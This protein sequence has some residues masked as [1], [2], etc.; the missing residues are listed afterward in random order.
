MNTT[1]RRPRALAVV[2]CL[3]G[4]WSPGVPAQEVEP[5][6]VAP[7]ATPR[8]V[9]EIPEV[10]A[11]SQ[12]TQLRL[13]EID[14][15]VASAP[16]GEIVAELDDFAN[17]VAER[18]VTVDETRLDTLPQLGREELEQEWQGYRS[19]LAGWQARLLEISSAFEANRLELDETRD[20]WQRTMVG[21][22]DEEAP[23]VLLGRIR[24]V[25]SSLDSTRDEVSAARDAALTALDT[26]ADIRIEVD[27][28]LE[29]IAASS[30]DI[31]ARMLTRDSPP[32]WSVLAGAPRRD[33]GDEVGV[34]LLRPPA[35]G[36]DELSLDR[37]RRFVEREWAS[38]E[39]ILVLLVALAVVLLVARR[40]LARDQVDEA[41]RPRI[42][43]VVQRPLA[44]AVLT[45]A[46]MAAWLVPGMP[47]IVR[48]VVSLVVLASWLRL[49][50]VAAPGPLRLGFYAIAVVYLADHYGR[51]LIEDQPWSRLY[52]LA[53]S[54]AAAAIGVRALRRDGPLRAMMPVGWG[55]LFRALV[56]VATL[57]LI[58]AA[59]ANIVG[60]VTL[61]QLLTRATVTSAAV[62]AVL[63]LAV[64]VLDAVVLLLM[65]RS[66][67]WLLRAVHDNARKIEG[68]LLGLV[69]LGAMVIWT[70]ATLTQFGVRDRF[71]AWLGDAITREWVVGNA[72]FSLAKV[73]TIVAVFIATLLVSRLIRALLE[74]DVFTRVELPR[75]VPNAVSTLVR[76]AFV[77]LALL[78]APLAAGV[79]FSNLAFIAG[80]L[81]VGIG[82]GLQNIVANFVSGLI[83]AF[84]RPVQVGDT[85]Q[86]AGHLGSVR[87]I[88]VRSSTIR[89]FDGADV[90]VPNSN[91]VSDVVLNWTLSDMRRRMQ[92]D[93]TVAYGADPHRVLELLRQAAAGHED[94]FDD[95]PPLA[96]FRGFTDT[97][98]AFRLLFW[99]P[100]AKALTAPSEVG[101]AIFDALEREGYDMPI[102]RQRVDVQEHRDDERRSES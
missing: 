11:R 73:L 95:P 33:D 85:I 24:E 23:D 72:S 37:L 19:R 41:V 74:H 47:L 15:A 67:P 25:I 100:T 44:G 3:W 50:P 46:L 86:A 1:A 14:E 59:I 20:L 8:P 34:G 83:L 4:L 60:A 57:L 66:T 62:A 12:E 101:L 27:R 94:V 28:V 81:G 5:S 17:R 79:D 93:V 91:M 69:S 40:R 88:G 18:L 2:L 49:I 87:S 38:L 56:P 68:W 10:T 35:P 22:E 84:E 61:A 90:V 52:L 43:A 77:A 16:T 89:T 54:I 58:V 97:G 30:S 98:L 63:F 32:L 42:A 51:L 29:E 48:E 92:L 78:L 70:E 71:A 13:K 55:R 96:L 102:P 6:V 80:G 76:Y 9:I 64:L 45:T 53:V 39:L 26:V 82:F 7:T 75:G 36:P 65:R 21:A 31:W 99:I